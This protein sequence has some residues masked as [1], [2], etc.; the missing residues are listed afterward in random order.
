MSI[1]QDKGC[2]TGTAQTVAMY[3]RDTDKHLEGCQRING[4]DIGFVRRAVFESIK[5]VGTL[6][7]ETDGRIGLG[8]VNG[9]FGHS[10]Y[11]F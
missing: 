11:F 7:N 4:T 3:R 5:P 2:F 10:R 1:G 8:K 9:L 6:R